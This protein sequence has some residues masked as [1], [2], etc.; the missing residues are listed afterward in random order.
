MS[1]IGLYF[2]GLASLCLIGGVSMGMYMGIAHDFQLSPVHAHLNLVGWASLALFGLAYSAVPRL[3][4]G[5]LPQ[6]H[7]LL[8]GVSGPLFP[9]GIYLSIFKD[10]K[11]LTAIAAP[12]WM[13]GVI[14]FAVIVW[15]AVL[16]RTSD[17]ASE[18]NPALA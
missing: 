1:R 14:L 8:C 3:D 13:I 4:E 2:L 17:E 9:L 10:S 6:L 7:L 15:R 11:G 5:R 12:M 16:R 18:P